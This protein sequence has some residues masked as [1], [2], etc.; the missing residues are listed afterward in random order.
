MFNDLREIVPPNSHGRSRQ[1]ESA[2]AHHHKAHTHNNL[3]R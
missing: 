2:I 3:Q 1:F